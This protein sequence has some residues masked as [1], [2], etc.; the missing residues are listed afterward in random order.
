MLDAEDFRDVPTSAAPLWIPPDP[1]CG[2]DVARLLYRLF[3]PESDIRS[4][5]IGLSRSG[6]EDAHRTR[7]GR[8]QRASESCVNGTGLGADGGFLPSTARVAFPALI[9]RHCGGDGGGASSGGGAAFGGTTW[10]ESDDKTCKALE[11]DV[12]ALA[13]LMFVEW[14]EFVSALPGCGAVLSRETSALWLAQVKAFVYFLC[15]GQACGGGVGIICLIMSQLYCGRGAGG[16]F[17]T[18][19]RLCACESSKPI[20]TLLQ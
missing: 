9:A 2:V 19:G 16:F 7:R 14:R 17:K 3:A 8:D 10:L 18:C 1:S 11:R 13:T 5:A 15:C 12:H 20:V 4:A 6:D